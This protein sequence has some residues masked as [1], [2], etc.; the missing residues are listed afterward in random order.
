MGD[1]QDRFREYRLSSE[2][3]RPL[4]S[5][6]YA[7]SKPYT[8]LVAPQSTSTMYI[9]GTSYIPQSTQ[10]SYQTPISATNQQQSPLTIVG[11]S[12]S[13]YRTSIGDNGSLNNQPRMSDLSK[14]GVSYTIP[15]KGEGGR[16]TSSLP[17]NGM[18]TAFASN[19]GMSI[20]Q[21]SATTGIYNTPSNLSPYPQFSTATGMQA[22][23]I[24][25]Y[26]QDGTGRPSLSNFANDMAPKSKI[27]Q[28]NFLHDYNNKQ[29]PLQQNNRP[30]ISIQGNRV[31][32]NLDS[33]RGTREE[34]QNTGY[35]IAQM[36]SPEIGKMQLADRM[37]PTYNKNPNGDYIELKDDFLFVPSNRNVDSL[38]DIDEEKDD[39]DELKDPSN[40]QSIQKSARELKDLYALAMHN[41]IDESQAQ[42]IE[43]YKR[44]SI[45]Q[46]EEG[47]VNYR[48]NDLATLPSSGK[49][50]RTSGAYIPDNRKI[51]GYESEVVKWSH[52]V[53]IWSQS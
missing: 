23:T 4:P 29:Q 7:P 20:P 14:Q 50:N 21:S 43:E 5:T 53:Q 6:G 52:L 18:S 35:M 32:S 33:M 28:S 16:V 38:A 41:N 49:I 46:D 10:P 51:P 39:V 34:N 17:S 26:T 36:T 27:L 19:S 15:L 8:S 45:I 30:S 25:N 12:V 31:G 3:E 11:N 44:K 48:K 9:P 24:N 40:I 22:Q 1:G 37:T 2:I 42:L 13:P 47:G